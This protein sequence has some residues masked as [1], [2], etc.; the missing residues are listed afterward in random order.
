MAKRDLGERVAAAAQRALDN[1]KY[2]SA[3]DVLNWMGML[4]PYYL[5]KW[6]RGEVPHLEGIIQCGPAKLSNAMR[7][8]RS[9]AEARG[10][11]PSEAVYTTDARG[12]KT[13]GHAAPPHQRRRLDHAHSS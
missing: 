11:K 13:D 3:V 5:E 8:F 2:V 9:W 12:G 6:R 1:Q 7:L 10:L 4:S